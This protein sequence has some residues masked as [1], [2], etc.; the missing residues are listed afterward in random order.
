MWRC[1]CR[2][3]LLC[4][5]THHYARSDGKVRNTIEFATDA[6]TQCCAACRVPGWLTEQAECSGWRL[7]PTTPGSFNSSGNSIFAHIRTRNNHVLCFWMF[8]IIETL[9]CVWVCVNMNRQLHALLR[10]DAYDAYGVI[11]HCGD[12]AHSPEPPGT[13]YILAHGTGHNVLIACVNLQLS[14][15]ADHCLCLARMP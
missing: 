14:L 7:I 9:C 3:S 5:R 15:C 10:R 4:A 1:V 6:A 11:L 2:C 8:Y 12:K 13:S